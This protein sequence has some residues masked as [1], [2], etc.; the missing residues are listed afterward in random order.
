MLSA[1]LYPLLTGLMDLTFPSDFAP[2]MRGALLSQLVVV[3]LATAA[4]ACLSFADRTTTFS[5]ATDLDDERSADAYDA[6]PPA[7][8]QEGASGYYAAPPS[9]E[10]AAADGGVPQV[11]AQSV[12][13]WAVRRIEVCRMYLAVANAYSVSAMSVALAYL[14]AFLQSLSA[15]GFSNQEEGR[16]AWR[17]VGGNSSAAASSL[18]A[19][20]YRSTPRLDWIQ[21]AVGGENAWVDKVSRSVI[22]CVATTGS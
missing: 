18:A 15:W 13:A 6:A 22:L 1:V 8:F 21:A 7:S 11:Q 20:T 17:N 3:M 14:A 5:A 10:A 19:F 16:V 12:L 9:T 2:A 4:M